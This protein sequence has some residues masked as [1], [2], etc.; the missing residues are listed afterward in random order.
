MPLSEFPSVHATIDIAASPAVVWALVSD[1]TLPARFSKEFT[2]AEWLSEPPHGV[3][4]QFEGHNGR[5]ERTWSTTCTVVAWSPERSFAWAVGDRDLPLAWWSFAL[6]P[7]DGGTRLVFHATAGLGESGLSRAVEGDPAN[8][9]TMI[10]GRLET[11][12]LNMQRTVEG[13][14]DLAEAS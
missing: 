7:L 12:R 2:G 9:E 3:G 1:I 14:R 5:G 8:A 13:V 11:W 4:S 6:E 10:A